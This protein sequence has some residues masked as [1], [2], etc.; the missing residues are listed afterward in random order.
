MAVNVVSPGANSLSGPAC[1]VAE[2]LNVNRFLPEHYYHKELVKVGSSL[3]A[4][5]HSIEGTDGN[6][7]CTRPAPLP[8]SSPALERLPSFLKCRLGVKATKAIALLRTRLLA[9][10]VWHGGTA[11]L[12]TLV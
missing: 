11:A 2:E 9:R 8:Y 5:N 7:L 6:L 12:R 10:G 4:L 1:K 3:N